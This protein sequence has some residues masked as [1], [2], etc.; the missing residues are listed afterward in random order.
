MTAADVNTIIGS[1]TAGL[2]AILTAWRAGEAVSRRQLVSRRRDD[3]Q[4]PGGGQPTDPPSGQA[5]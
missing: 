5:P 2:V 4:P 1:V 3:P